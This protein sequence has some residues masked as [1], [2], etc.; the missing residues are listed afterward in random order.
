[1]DFLLVT[2]VSANDIFIYNMAKWLQKRLNANIDVFA[3][4]NHNTQTY[5]SS[6]FREVKYVEDDT[7]ALTRKLFGWTQAY[8]YSRQLTKFLR[9]KKYDIIQ[10]HWMVPAIALN[11]QLKNHC[12]KLF[13]TF[14]G[15]EFE[16]MKILK[17]KRLYKYYINRFSASVD[18]MINSKENQS[19]FLCLLPKFAGRYY[20]GSFGSEP[21]EKLYSL[22]D[23]ETKDESKRLLGIN[24]SKVSVLIG[25]SGKKLHQHLEVIDVLKQFPVLKDKIVVL[26]PMTRN[27]DEK[28]VND[29]SSKLNEL[30]IEYWIQDGFLSDDEIVRLRNATDF[31]MQYAKFD[32]F[33]RSIVE[34]ICAKSLMVYGD[35]INYDAHLKRFN[36]FAIK[37]KN[38]EE[39]IEVLI[40]YLKSPEEYNKLLEKNHE[41]G[42]HSYFWS[43]C[44]NN[45]VNAYLGK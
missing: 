27:Y 39:G 29:V 5:D 19:K 11:R 26:A 40:D 37:T 33:S 2:G 24:Q 9:G 6:I 1:M 7:N 35:W 31:T 45:W 44:I 4:D 17:S 41:N 12:E 22:M 18:G 3:I 28:Y 21:L 20:D 13:M 23:I 30:G 43:E 32:D 14:W 34:C 10:C 36:F 16:D 25:Y 15:G 42:K 8:R 38:I